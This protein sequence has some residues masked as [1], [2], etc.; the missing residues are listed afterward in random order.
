MKLMELMVEDGNK[1][2]DEEVIKRLQSMLYV[3]IDEASN[4]S[5][6]GVSF[7]FTLGDVVHETGYLGG[8][9]V[10]VNNE[11]D[12]YPSLHIRVKAEKG[13]PSANGEQEIIYRA[14]VLVNVTSN[15]QLDIVKQLLTAAGSARGIRVHWKSMSPWYHK[16][17]M[18]VTGE[19]TVMQRTIQGVAPTQNRGGARYDPRAAFNASPGE[20]AR[21]RRVGQSQYRDSFGGDS[22]NYR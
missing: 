20:Q 3:F 6:P 8:I 15:K 12:E 10:A 18:A 1:A 17:H 16:T 2:F 11:D 4:Y 13:V 21:Q 19:F 7:F 14:T 5:E 22:S 9:S